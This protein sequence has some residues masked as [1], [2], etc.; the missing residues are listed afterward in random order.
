[1]ADPSQEI[2]CLRS[3]FLYIYE[4]N[5][6]YRLGRFKYRQNIQ[7]KVRIRCVVYN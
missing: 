4:C 2:V 3:L 1:M 7:L 5:N 6:N